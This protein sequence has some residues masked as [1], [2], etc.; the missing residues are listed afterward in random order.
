M[1]ELDAFITHEMRQKD[2]PAFTIAVIDDQ[3]VVWSKD[4]GSTRGA[5]TVEPTPATVYRVGAVSQIVTDL[6]VMQLVEHGA[7]DL[8]APIERYVPGLHLDT[9]TPVTLRTLMAG[10]A[11]LD[12]EPP[13]GGLDD[14][15]PPALSVI[16]RSLSASPPLAESGR[17][18]DPS[19]AGITLA[20]YV[21]EATQH[22][23]FARYVD[24]AVLHPLG[25]SHATF[26]RDSNVALH[27]ARGAMWTY[28]PRDLPAPTF[29]VGIA[30]AENLYA[31]TAD[32]ARLL[33]AIFADGRAAN[34]RVLEPGAIARML[35]T[36]TPANTARIALGF[37][38]TQLDGREELEQQ[39][40]I[41]G[42]S[43]TIAALPNDKLGVVAITT[44]DGATAVTQRVASLALRI[45]LAARHGN[46]PPPI[47]TSTDVPAP[48]A[49]SLAGH[50]PH[51]DDAVDL[52]HT[53]GHLYFERAQGGVRAD[54][55]LLGDTLVA[56]GRLSFG[57]RVIRAGDS[58]IVVDGDTLR[59]AAEPEPE[60]VPDA[61]R[62]LIGEYG[63]DFRTAYVLERH[64]T[65]E[66][67]ADWF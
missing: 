6:A 12:R 2:L 47:D 5:D 37:R 10:R 16:V 36:S 46:T 18:R 11:A 24:G 59:R 61:W 42:F 51:G 38:L 41:G 30:P 54:L 7:L 56:D 45:M 31:T 4:Y 34:N 13:V 53:M 17:A 28:D 63:P 20:G 52:V 43:S 48:L 44:V 64:G 60:P 21:L 57:T 23:P 26:A 19:D 8:D 35:R 62:G 32:L 66:L 65:L 55:H 27:L 58:S 40:A 49:Q 25:M 1:A 14:A 67:L 29:D 39:G 9:G 33:S 15:R 3:R 50:Y 22:Q